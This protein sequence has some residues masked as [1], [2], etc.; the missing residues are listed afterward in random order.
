MAQKKDDPTVTSVGPEYP[1]GTHA[2]RQASEVTTSAAKLEYRDL[3]ADR[4]PDPSTIAQEQVL[5]EDK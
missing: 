4:K 1:E 5:P 3:P 2:A